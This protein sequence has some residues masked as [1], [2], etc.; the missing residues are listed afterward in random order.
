MTL[1]DKKPE[2]TPDE[3]AATQ[4]NGQQAATTV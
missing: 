4:S 3:K 2:E 1:L